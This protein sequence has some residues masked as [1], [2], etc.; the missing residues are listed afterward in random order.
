LITSSR[1]SESLSS[2]ISEN[3]PFILEI[4]DA[5]IIILFLL[6]IIGMLFF[7]FNFSRF[8][9][10]SFQFKKNPSGVLTG[11]PYKSI[12]F[13]VV[14]GMLIFVIS[15]V[16]ILQ[17]RGQVNS[18]LGHLDDQAIVRVNDTV[19]EN[20]EEIVSELKTMA[21]LEPHH[22]HHEGRIAVMIENGDSKL[23]LELG[24]D[25][26]N[27]NEYWVFYAKYLST[28]SNEVGRI[29]SDKFDRFDAISRESD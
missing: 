7:V 20:P 3:D 8:W 24:R 10:R 4:L 6:G 29:I 27:P 1:L 22:S 12:L 14:P 13:F 5:T 17:A 15:D 25:S 18:F 11:M 23:D 16:L 2:L 21:P 9:F 28:E 26:Q 19:I